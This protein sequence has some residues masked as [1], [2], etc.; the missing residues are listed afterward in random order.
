MPKCLIYAPL[1]GRGGVHRMVTR[2]ARAWAK[3]PGWEFSILSQRLDEN[4]TPIDWP[5]E[6][7]FEQIDGGE[8]PRHPELFPWLYANQP[9]FYAHWARTKADIAYLPMP[10]WTARLPYWKPPMPTVITLH[11]FAWDQT[12]QRNHEFRAEARVF[13]QSGV[14]TVFPSHYQRQ[15]GIDHYGFRDTST[16]YHGHFIPDGMMATPTEASRIRENY[17]LPP[18]YLLAFHVANAKKDPFTILTAVANARKRSKHVPPLVIA[19]LDTQMMAPPFVPE[20]HFA[21]SFV[22][23]V[24]ACVEACGFTYG[25]DLFVLGAVPEADIGG[26][27]AGAAAAITASHNEGGIPGSMFEAFAAHTPAIYTDLPIFSERLKPNEYGWVFEPK[28]SEALAQAIIEVCEKP[29]EGFKRAAKA[30]AFANS[31]TWD[32][33][34]GEYITLFEE[35]ISEHAQA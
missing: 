28:D 26:L 34:A 4:G 30:F 27:Y 9:T 22:Q 13:A 14:P 3:L 19:G 11:D 12:G 2:L 17:G 33:A 16:I 25:K 7:P 31:R 1:I 29:D 15:W 6:L 23:S 18:E 24:R 5:K 8:A 10:W 21:H 35:V 20:T 32:D